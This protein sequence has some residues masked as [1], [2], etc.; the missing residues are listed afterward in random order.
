MLFQST[1][2]LGSQAQPC[3]FSQGSLSEAKAQG[4]LRSKM[5]DGASE[6]RASLLAKGF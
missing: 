4:Y 3:V 5:S 1:S 6:F 2:P